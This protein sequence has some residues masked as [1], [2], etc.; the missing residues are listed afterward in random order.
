MDQL[1]E[2]KHLVKQYRFA[3]NMHA[4][5]PCNE[6]NSIMNRRYD[7]IIKHLLE[8]KQF[9]VLEIRIYFCK[10]DNLIGTKIL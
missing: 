9:N 8:H 10:L 5:R 4:K 6:Y 7:A 2:L 1:K 3:M